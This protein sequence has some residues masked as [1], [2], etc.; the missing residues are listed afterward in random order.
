MYNKRRLTS[1][2][3]DGV[4]LHITGTT[5]T[6]RS[7]TQTEGLPLQTDVDNNTGHT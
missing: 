7:F 2:T 4:G 6:V 3:N 5:N 1:A